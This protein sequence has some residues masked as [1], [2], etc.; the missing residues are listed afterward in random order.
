MNEK[1]AT[2]WLPAILFAVGA[3]ACAL[4]AAPQARAATITLVTT[5]A[6][7]PNEWPIFIA[8]KKNFFTEA[9]VDLVSV[10]APSTSNAVQ[11]VAAGSADME[12]GG[13][14]DRFAPSRTARAFR[15]SASTR[16]FPPSLSGASRA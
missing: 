1:R 15:S 9:S 5:G 7:N 14:T 12:S 8:R 3:A 13:I 6:N 10:S 4:V 2:K 16:R 11:Q